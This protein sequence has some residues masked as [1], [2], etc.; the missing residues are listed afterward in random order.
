MHIYFRIVYTKYNERANYITSVYFEGHNLS[1]GGPS[2]RPNIQE[3]SD[4]NQTLP[5]TELRSL[6]NTESMSRR[7]VETSHTRNR[8]QDM[9]AM[10]PQRLA[11]ENRRDTGNDIICTIMTL[12]LFGLSKQPRPTSN[13]S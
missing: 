3:Q 8:A 13:C 7:E 10:Q 5:R 1:N 11:Y 6:A 4:T 12:N 9:N 2:Q